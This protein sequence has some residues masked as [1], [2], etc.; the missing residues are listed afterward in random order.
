MLATKTT[1]A[2]ESRFVQNGTKIILTVK[3]STVSS[4][5]SAHDRRRVTQSIVSKTIKDTNRIL[6]EGFK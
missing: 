1:V 5:L 4:S 3:V 2:E 6:K